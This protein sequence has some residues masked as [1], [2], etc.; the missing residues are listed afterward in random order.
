MDNRQK[1]PEPDRTGYQGRKG[2][3]RRVL[4]GES[5]KERKSPAGDRIRG[6]FGQHE[7]DVYQ[8]VY[9]L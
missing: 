2:R 1:D 4:Y 5:R 6:G 7:E 9:L 3:K 8:Y